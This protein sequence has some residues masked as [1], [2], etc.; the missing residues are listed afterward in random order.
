MLYAYKV[1]LQL[2]YWD[3]PRVFSDLHFPDEMTVALAHVDFTTAGCLLP[4]L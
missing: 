1:E 2:P 4:E 3:S